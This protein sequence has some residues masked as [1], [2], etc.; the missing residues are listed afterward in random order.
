[1]SSRLATASLL[2]LFTPLLLQAADPPPAMINEINYNSP[3]SLN[4]DDWIEFY[5]SGSD[6]VDM[7]NWIFMDEDPSPFYTFPAGTTLGAHGY[8]VV[9]RDTVQFATWHPEVENRLGNFD[10][11]L[12]GGGELLRLY[13]SDGTVVDSLTYDDKAPWPSKANGHGATLVLTDPTLDNALPDNWV[14]SVMDGGTPGRPNTRQG[15]VVI[16]E[17]MAEN[18]RTAR[19]ARRP[20]RGVPDR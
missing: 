17:F 4:P 6:A 15:L 12:S 19:D 16:N 20:E 9:C 1:M 7:S 5:N 14:A 11:G 3:D 10:F 13:D 2:V 18:A 8:F